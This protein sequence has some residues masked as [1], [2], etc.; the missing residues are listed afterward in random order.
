[1][2]VR[3]ALPILNPRMRPSRNIWRT[4]SGCT[5][6][7]NYAKKLYY[8]SG[9]YDA[10]NNAYGAVY[11]DGSS[12]SAT[13]TGCRLVNNLGVSPFDG[14][15]G[16]VGGNRIGPGVIWMGWHGEHRV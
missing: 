3:Q 1:M 12:L 16:F 8:N 2:V 7:G 15:S 14:A 6:S 13:F 9:Y 11:M 5:L 10:P 4:V